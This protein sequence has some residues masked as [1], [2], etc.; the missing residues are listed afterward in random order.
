MPKARKPVNIDGVEFDALLDE[1]RMLE[2]EAPDYAVED[3]FSVCDTIILKPQTL[4]MTLFVTDTPVTWQKS[5]HGGVGWTDQVIQKLEDLYYAKKPVT[6]NTSERSYRNMAILS[7][8]I[9]KSADVGYARQI[10]ISFREIIVVSTKKT[11]IP[12]SYGKSGNSGANA[13]TAATSVSNAPPAAGSPSGG[14]T[15]ADGG[16][17]GSAAYNLS[18]NAGLL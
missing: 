3:G 2:A 6:V 12:A 4:S 13:G 8:S 1:E 15:S 7:I 17:K 18:K 16:S 9:S 11:A 14:T 10:P 5:G